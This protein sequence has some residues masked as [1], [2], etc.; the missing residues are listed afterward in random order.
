MVDHLLIV[1]HA[2]AD[3]IVYG[4]Q[5][6]KPTPEDIP[7]KVMQHKILK[8]ILELSLHMKMLR[9]RHSN[10][11]LQETLLGTL[12]GNITKLVTCDEYNFRYDLGIGNLSFCTT[13][14]DQLRITDCMC[15]HYVILNIK[16]ELNCGLSSN[17]K[18]SLFNT[19]GIL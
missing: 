19:K 7:D 10:G 14:S 5:N 9:L 18:C 2:V 16:A 15:K 13:M 12:L 8:L 3:Y 17:V 11:Y 4:I 6:V 1:C